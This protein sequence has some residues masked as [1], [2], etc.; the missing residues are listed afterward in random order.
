MRHLFILNPCAGKKDNSGAWREKI[1]S[2]C[3]SRGADYSIHVTT[4][5]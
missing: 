3:Q 4:G 1:E 2:A 5:A